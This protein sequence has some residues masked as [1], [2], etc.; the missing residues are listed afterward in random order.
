MGGHLGKEPLSN[1]VNLGTY[2]CAMIGLDSSGKT[3]VL[4]RLKFDQYMNT[5]PT[6]GFNCEKVRTGG[7]NFLVWDVG[8]QD[9]LRPLWRSY[10]RCTDG[11]I[12]VIDSCQVDRLEEAKLELLKICKSNKSVPLLILAN[13][14]DLPE[15]CSTS[16]L[17]SSLGLKD[18]GVNTPWHI[19]STCA[20]TGE[21]LEEGM[22]KLHRMIAV[23]RKKNIKVSRKVQRSHSY[24]H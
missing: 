18:L 6:I 5:A 11:I 7:V 20:V 21:G 16:K 17:E 9:K 22:D 1:L 10:T 15:A 13:K 2:H 8:G 24:H 12:F 23:K 14:Q 4:Y 3:T 19:Q